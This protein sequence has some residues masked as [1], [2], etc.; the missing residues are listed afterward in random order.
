WQYQTIIS[1]Q[2]ETQ[3]IYQLMLQIITESGKELSGSDYLE[4]ASKTGLIMV[5]DRFTLEHAIRIIR[6]GEQKNI[7][8]RTLLNQVFSDYQSRDLRTKKLATITKLN[9]PIGSMI[10]Q[11]SQ[12]EAVE[13][14][15]ILGEIASELKQAKIKVC[16]S[17]F[18]FTKAAWNIA[19]KFNVGW[20]RL[21][22]FDKHSPILDSDNPDSLQKIIRKAHVLGYKVIVT[23]VDSAGFA[24]DLW[25]LDVDYL[26]GNFIQTPVRDI[27]SD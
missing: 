27:F 1:T 9:L 16:L 12:N 14:I 5:L 20:I 2:D 26:Q 19:R 18:D 23:R 17:D 3:E 4:V 7:Y 11:F 8:S 6:A 15:S 13:N 21:K 22:P 24:A 10:F 25:K